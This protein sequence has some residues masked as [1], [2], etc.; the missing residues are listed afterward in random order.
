MTK[1][2]AIKHKTSLLIEPYGGKLVDLRLSSEELAERKAYASKLP[3][4]QVSSRIACDLELLAI[5]AFSP[6]DRFMGAEDNRRVVN[7]LRLSSGHLFPVPITLPVDQGDG[8]K[9]DVEIALRDAKNNL[10]AVMTIEEIYEPYL[11]KEGFLKRTP[12]GREAT[13]LAYQTLNIPFP[14][15]VQE[16]AAT[17]L[18]IWDIP[19]SNSSF[20]A[21]MEMRIWGSSSKAAPGTVT[22]D[23][24][25]SR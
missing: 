17:A 25:S 13:S 16:R 21:A 19:C 11:I 10:L 12:R 4:I 2:S 14:G 3:S 22:T 8:I 23:Q 15:S 1:G 5:G 7:E 6:L 24:S 18:T 9:L 20:D